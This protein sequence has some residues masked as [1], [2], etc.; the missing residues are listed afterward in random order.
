[1]TSSTLVELLK[2]NGFATL[3]A[4][5][6]YMKGKAKRNEWGSV[7][8]E[9]K[10]NGLEFNYSHNCKH[11]FGIQAPINGMLQFYRFN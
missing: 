1:M 2:E 10:R 9:E 4:F 5:K 8:Y 7:C 11:V 3:D 6:K